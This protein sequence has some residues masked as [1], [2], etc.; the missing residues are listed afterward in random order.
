M[1]YRRRV[2]K[3]FPTRG[4]YQEGW[5]TD[6]PPTGDRT[7]IYR[8]RTVSR[9]G[10]NGFPTHGGS[11]RGISFRGISHGPYQEGWERISHPRGDFPR[12]TGGK[13]I[14]H[15]RGISYPRGMSSVQSKLPTYFF[16]LHDAPHTGS[17]HGC[18]VY[19]CIVY[20]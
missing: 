19:D 6:F 2:G 9:R 18:R 17:W 13:R 14:S 5:E 10:G 1:I 11:S 8:P 7:G 12:T 16:K 20:L 3:G 15:P 4:P